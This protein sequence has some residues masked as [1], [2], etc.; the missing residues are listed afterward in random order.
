MLYTPVR[1]VDMENF[2]LHRTFTSW[3]VHLLFL[4]TLPTLA[5]V[6]TLI[7]ENGVRIEYQDEPSPSLRKLD[8]RMLVDIAKKLPNLG[9]LRCKAGGDEWPN[10]LKM[11]AARAMTNDWEG[12]RRD[13]RHDFSKALSTISLP[14]LQHAHLDFIHPLSYTDWIDHRH[15]MPNLTAP[16][17]QSP[18]PLLQPTHP[19]PPTRRRRN[20]LLAHRLQYPIMA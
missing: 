20:T 10:G 9:K 12:P 18:P 19:K 13:S 1:I 16:S 6:Q 8:L 3:R 2:C 15:A 4:E 17:I 14:K 11:E 5:S 7:V